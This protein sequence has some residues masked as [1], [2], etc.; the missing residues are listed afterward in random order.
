MSGSKPERRTI[1]AWCVLAVPAA[2]FLLFGIGEFDLIH[3]GQ[4]AIVIAVGWLS[5]RHVRPAGITSL[6]LGVLAAIAFWF[7]LFALLL[8]AAPLAIAG[9]LLLTSRSRA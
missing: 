5:R 2:V 7:S 6:A 8:V 4:A 1:A 3:L 9:V